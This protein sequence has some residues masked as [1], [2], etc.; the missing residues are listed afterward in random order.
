[1][2]FFVQL[3]LFTA[4]TFAAV[5]KEIVY[6]GLLTDKNGI[7]FTDGNYIVTFN[8]Y[9]TVSGEDVAWTETQTVALKQGQFTA[10]IGSTNGGINLPFDTQYWLS[11]TYNTKE[12]T[13]RIKIGSAVYAMRSAIADSSIRTT[14]AAVADSSLKTV[15]A[16]TASKA[17]FA[18]SAGSVSANSHVHSWLSK[19]N[20][21]VDTALVVDTNGNVGIGRNDPQCKLDVYGRCSAFGDSLNYDN[22]ITIR[23]GTKEGG[24]VVLNDKQNAASSENTQCWSID[25]DENKKLRFFRN[26]NVPLTIDSTGNVGIGTGTPMDNL[27]IVDTNKTKPNSCAGITIESAWTAGAT[28]KFKPTYTGG[29]LWFVQAT[30]ESAG[31]G[32][33]RLVITS[34]SSIP[35]FFD[36][37]VIDTN[38]NVSIG[39]SRTISSPINPNRLWVGGDVAVTGT[40]TCHGTTCPSDRRFKTSITPIEN[41]LEKIASLQGVSY[42]WDKAKFPERNFPDGKQIGLI[43]QDVE[44]VLPEIVH[45]NAEGYKSL[46]YDKMTAVL[47]E[48]VKS[49]QKVIEELKEQNKEFQK[50]IEALEKR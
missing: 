32:A 1:M 23:G 36:G 33:N 42:Y 16:D 19:K 6:Q 40:I 10:S 26:G 39:V 12:L 45:T 14:W 11:I 47:I 4:F 8:L 27:H 15:K 13:P 18:T 49:Q 46:S 20:R 21:S 28:L 34:G 25:N 41:S 30:A 3:L 43:A 29:S 48:A 37:I 5:P 7:A 31:Q 2:K 9:P 17:G 35:R 50:R 24:Q 22:S 44:M 38:N